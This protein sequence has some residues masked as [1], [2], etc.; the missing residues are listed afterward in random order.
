MTMDETMKKIQRLNRIIA[1]EG[2]DGTGKESVSR[3]LCELLREYEFTADMVSFPRYDTTVGKVIKEFQSG[4]YGFPASTD[5]YISG[6]PYTLDRINFFRTMDK[7]WFRSLDF[8]ILDRSYFSNYLYQGPKFNVEK[9]GD[10]RRLRDWMRMSYEAEISTI[11]EMDH[12]F[13]RVYFLQLSDE[14]Q[15]E[16]LK[17]RKE[18]DMNESNREY[19]NSIR[20]FFY[21]ARSYNF[22]AGI[23]AARKTHVPWYGDTEVLT[24]EEWYL[25]R[26][27]KIESIHTKDPDKIPEAVNETANKILSDIKCDFISPSVVERILPRH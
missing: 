16:Q 6:A 11:P 3:R 26:V 9:T 8:L 17:S 15:Q 24:L 18:L 23:A 22:W 27:M 14:D 25:R 10:Y 21:H 20:D 2:L 19:Q 4:F 12:R 5:P 7:E 13:H 1:I